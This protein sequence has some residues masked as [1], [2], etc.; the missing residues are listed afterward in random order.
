MAPK[1]KFYSFNGRSRKALVWPGGETF[2]DLFHESLCKGTLGNFS[3]SNYFRSLC[4]NTETPF[5][6]KES[7]LTA[8]TLN[9]DCFELGVR[10]QRPYA[11]F[12][13]H[14]NFGSFV[15]ENLRGINGRCIPIRSDSALRT[16]VAKKA[17]SLLAKL[18]WSPPGFGVLH[19]DSHLANFV[20]PGVASL[21]YED[22]D[23]AVV[24]FDQS[25]K[26]SS[27]KRRFAP[28]E[29]DITKLEEDCSI[30]LALTSI[31]FDELIAS[32]YLSHVPSNLRGEVELRLRTAL[33]ISRRS[34]DWG[35]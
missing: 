6:Y 8:A 20:L 3:P 1:Q 19:G 30:N 12:F 15:F 35:F 2:A 4:P 21:P 9:A 5:L 11:L 10:T 23:L 18:H 27:P 28:F 32:T 16:N 24:D 31:T 22:F 13:T 33:T 26:F 29:R 25:E 17:I 7:F 34:C 14:E